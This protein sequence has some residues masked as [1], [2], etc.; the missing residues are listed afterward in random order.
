MFNSVDTDTKSVLYQDLIAVLAGA[1]QEQAASMEAMGRLI[2]S[3]AEAITGLV[4]REKALQRRVDEGDQH[5]VSIERKFQELTTLLEI[6]S[7][8]S[9]ESKE[10]HP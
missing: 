4:Q 6:L 9:T 8:S 3:Q 2:E 10:K 1:V 7:Q 5:L